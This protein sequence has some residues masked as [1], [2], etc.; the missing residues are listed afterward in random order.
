MWLKR[1]LEGIGADVKLLLPDGAGFSAAPPVVFGERHGD[2]GA[3]TLL[4]YGHYDV[5]PPDPLEEWRTPPFDPTEIGGRVYCRG[6]Q[7]DKGQ[8]GRAHV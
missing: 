2:E 6:A 7:D 4:F 3:P 1:W 5:Q 8:I